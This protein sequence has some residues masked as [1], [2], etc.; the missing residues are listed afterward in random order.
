MRSAGT[1]PRRRCWPRMAGAS[2]IPLLLG[3]IFYGLALEPSWRDAHRALDAC[4][5]TAEGLH[6]VV[7]RGRGV[8]G[9]GIANLAQRVAWIRQ[10]VA[11]TPRPAVFLEELGELTRELGIDRFEYHC[12]AAAAVAG[13]GYRVD[14]IDVRVVAP[15]GS[16]L[17]LWARLAAL[18]GPLR[19]RS[20]RLRRYGDAVAATFAIE[21]FSRIPEVAGPARRDRG[22]G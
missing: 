11:S 14:P 7:A 21:L 2:M 15:Y 10:Q 4:R 1:S 20:M 5:R 17:T 18:D 3:A 16:L 6:G 12:G 22:T 13:T 19:C 9:A 8:A